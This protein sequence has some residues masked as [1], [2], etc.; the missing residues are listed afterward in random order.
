MTSQPDEILRTAVASRMKGASSDHIDVITAVAGLMAAIAYSDRTITE[1]EMRLLRA[2]LSRI[3]ELG[4]VGADVVCETLSEHALRLST[5]F[6]PRFTRTLRDGLPLENR[7]EVLDALLKVAG[8]DG[9]I[10]FDEISSLR[11]ITTSL[12][13]SQAHY[14]QLQENY[15]DLLSHRS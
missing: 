9:S 1:E 14:N 12:G 7:L 2:E 8:A 13:L 5:S 10:T 6:V 3:D 11:N 15:K 4:P